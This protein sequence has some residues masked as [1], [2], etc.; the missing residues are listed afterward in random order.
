MHIK[1]VPT[2]EAIQ[3]TTVVVAVLAAAILLIEVSLASAISC[4]LGAAL[5]A[6]NLFAL[7]WIVRAIFA[8]ARQAGGATALGLIAAPMKMLLLA[9]IAFLIVKSGWVNVA[10]FVAGTLTQFAAIFIE[11][12]RASIGASF[13]LHHVGR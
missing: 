11:V 8:L 12:G 2:V 4:I 5:M 1:A 3:R 10:A 6:A 13:P 7:S 9:G